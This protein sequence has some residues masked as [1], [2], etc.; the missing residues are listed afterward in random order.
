L[1]GAAGASAEMI[2]AHLQRESAD[3]A[4]LLAKPLHLLDDLSL[5]ATAMAPALT[6]DDYARMGD[7]LEQT[8]RHLTDQEASHALRLSPRP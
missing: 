7:H 3:A 8:I 2:I 1:T 6:A 4:A 5:T